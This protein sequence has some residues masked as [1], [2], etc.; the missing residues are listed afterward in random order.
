MPETVSQ[1]NP[2]TNPET[3]PDK[4]ARINV[5]KLALLVSFV[6]SLLITAAA[7]GNSWD[8]KS[9]VGLGTV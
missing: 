3:K 2:K 9:V 5:I 4:N 8:A 1:D 7:G 6:C